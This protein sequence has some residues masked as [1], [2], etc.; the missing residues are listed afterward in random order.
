MT[1]QTYD[2][3][4]EPTAQEAVQRPNPDTKGGKSRAL[5]RDLLK[6]VLAEYA[7]LRAELMFFM[8]S[9]HVSH[10]FT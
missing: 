9:I 10:Q 1:K 8:Y 5:D 2:A 6:V 7:A 3:G 4:G